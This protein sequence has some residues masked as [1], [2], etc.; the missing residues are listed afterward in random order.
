MLDFGVK[1]CWSI[2]T[3]SVLEPGSNSSQSS[4]EMSKSKSPWESSLPSAIWFIL[5][6]ASYFSALSFERRMGFLLAGVTASPSQSASYSS[7]I[8]PSSSLMCLLELGM[9]ICWNRDPFATES[10]TD[11]GTLSML[12]SRSMLSEPIAITM[13]QFVFWCLKHRSN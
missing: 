5:I 3:K 7:K 13:K 4:A 8:W 6:S 10:E 12:L 2:M 9:L 11:S 1:V